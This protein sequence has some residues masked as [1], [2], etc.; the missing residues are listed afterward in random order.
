MRS[1]LE[2]RPLKSIN[3]LKTLQVGG[4]CDPEDFEYTT[5]KSNATNE[6][7]ASAMLKTI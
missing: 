7:K 2:P 1:V 5:Y 3:Q 6:T 4:T